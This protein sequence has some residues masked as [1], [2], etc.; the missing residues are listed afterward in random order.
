MKGRVPVK[1][2]L[3]ALGTAIRFTL[4]ALDKRKK[5]KEERNAVL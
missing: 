1:F 5:K 4:K 3:G 2:I